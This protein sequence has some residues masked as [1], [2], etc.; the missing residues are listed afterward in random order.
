MSYQPQWVD[1]KEVGTGRRPC[2]ERYAAI[3]EYLQGRFG[4]EQE[5][6]VLDFGAQSG[7]FSARLVDD[8]NAKATA[9]ESNRAALTHMTRDPR[10]RVIAARLTPEQITKLGKFDVVLGLS[11]LHHLPNW[12]RYLRELVAVGEVIFIETAHPKENLPKAVAHGESAAIENEVVALS[13]MDALALTAGYDA[14]YERPLYVIDRMVGVAPT[15]P[16]TKR[17]RKPKAA[18]AQTECV[19]GEPEKPGV[20]H[21]TDGPCYWDETPTDAEQAAADDA[22][23]DPEAN[24]LGDESLA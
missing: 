2:A 5:I 1:G 11:V 23:L 21:R 10:V 9:V 8:F 24:E 17:A 20:V 12:K 16:K 7:Y 18:P 19:C 15:A 6:T 3:A 22:V 13:T 14:D 4:E